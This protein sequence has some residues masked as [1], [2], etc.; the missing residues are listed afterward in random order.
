MK[1]KL[2]DVTINSFDDLDNLVNNLCS[3]RD[4]IKNHEYRDKFDI[5]IIYNKVLGIFESIWHF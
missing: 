3:L 4:S 5:K 1:I 2:E